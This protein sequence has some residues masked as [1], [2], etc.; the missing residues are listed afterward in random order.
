MSDQPP[1]PQ[2]PPHP[3][4]R[5]LFRSRKGPGPPGRDEKRFDIFVVDTWWNHPISKAVHSQLRHVFEFHQADHLYVLTPE[6]SFEIIRRNPDLVG[7]DPTLIVYDL[8]A[9]STSS[10][11]N[12]K[13]FRLNLGLMRNA[14][15]AIARLQEFLRFIAVHR[16]AEHLSDEVRK[17]LHR[18]GLD[19]MVKL[20]RE[21]SMELLVE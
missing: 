9:S 3:H 15:D 7:C 1:P 20:L 4:R 6:Q 16:T 10:P 13:G 11:S 18:K 17:E 19:G 21:S 14:E 2:H 12:Y 8:Y 5:G